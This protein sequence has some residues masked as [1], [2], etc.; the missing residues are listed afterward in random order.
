VDEGRLDADLSRR[1]VGMFET[2]KDKLDGL[3]ADGHGLRD[4]GQPGIDEV[5]PDETRDPA[6]A[7]ETR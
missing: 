2:P 4:D 1:A 5:G 7:C 3:G 6:T